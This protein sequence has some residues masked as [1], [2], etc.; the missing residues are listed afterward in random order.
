MEIE[1]P[2]AVANTWSTP[3][4]PHNDPAN[5][6]GGQRARDKQRAKMGRKTK[7]STLHKVIKMSGKWTSLRPGGDSTTKVK[8]G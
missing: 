3:A 7:D 2:K 4:S 8:T 5:P 6:M 1:S